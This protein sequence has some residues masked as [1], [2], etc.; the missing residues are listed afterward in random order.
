MGCSR[1]ASLDLVMHALRTLQSLLADPRRRLGAALMIVMLVLGVVTMHAMSGSS[2]AHGAPVATKHVD[3][4]ANA[5]PADPGHG[6]EVSAIDHSGDASQPCDHSCGG[7]ELMT[8]MCLMVLVV[9]LTLTVPVRRLFF[10]V[11]WTRAG[12]RTASPSRV[13]FSSA[14][15]LHALGISRT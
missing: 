9:L 7:H 12:P 10:V 3:A 2:T 8:A 14:P 11:G 4:G 5:D 15:S 13:V 6:Q 1:F